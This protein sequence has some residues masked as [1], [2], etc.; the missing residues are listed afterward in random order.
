MKNI[1]NKL[2]Y[3][4]LTSDIL[5]SAFSVHNTLGC[6]LLEKVYENSLAW[7]LELKNRKVE[8]QK[9]FRVFYKNKE[10]GLYIAD[11][12]VDRKVIIEAK[13]AEK[14]S[15]IHRAQLLNYLRISKCRV[16]LILNFTNPKL[17]YERLVV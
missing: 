10:V 7:D 6:G 11:L 16:G 15:D 8:I 9:E 1:R 5:D 4:D 14:I 3:G 17:E 12:V 2:I 13:C